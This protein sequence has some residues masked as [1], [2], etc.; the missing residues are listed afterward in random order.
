MDS[1]NNEFSNS[2]NNIASTS[3]NSREKETLDNSEL[4][5]KGLQ[6]LLE[7]INN[8]NHNNLEQITNAFI[9]TIEN[10]KIRSNNEDYNSINV[11]TKGDEGTN[12]V[13]F[14][15]KNF[16]LT[17]INFQQ[18]YK[19]LVH[20][21]ISTDLINF[22]EVQ[23]ETK[24][25][26]QLEIKKDN[27]TQS[28]IEYSLDEEGNDVLKGCKTAFEMMSRLKERYYQT[29]QSYID[30]I[31][32]QIKGLKIKDNDFLSYIHKMDELYNLR[33]TECDKLNKESLDDI[34]KITHIFKELINTRIHPLF[35]YLVDCNSY[36]EFKEKMYKLNSLMVTIKNLTDNN[37]FD[38]YNNNINRVQK[39]KLPYNFNF[40]KNTNQREKVHI[41][42][43]YC[44]ICEKYGHITKNCYKIKTNQSNSSNNKINKG[45]KRK[46]KLKTKKYNKI[47][48]SCNVENKIKKHT[49]QHSDSDSDVIKSLNFNS[50]YVSCSLAKNDFIKG[51]NKKRKFE[52]IDTSKNPNISSTSWIIDSGTAINLI[53]D[54]NKLTNVKE[55]EERTITYANG[56]TEIIKYVGMYKGEYKNKIFSIPNVYFASN[57]KNN[58]IS[59]NHILNMGFEL[60]IRKI[61]NKKVLTITKNNKYI[62][63]LNSNNEGLFVMKS[64]DLQTNNDVNY[65]EGIDC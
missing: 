14:H 44:Y 47:L 54:C 52:D 18:W 24:S 5:N 23:K 29:G 1:K 25:M 27:K 33:K 15:I 10:M 30:N 55:I 20:H 7:A 19:P 28:I 43:N 11:N 48:K 34:Y 4:V 16:H 13:P 60:N 39:G 51:H 46:L 65:V 26:N 8:N 12:N 50:N 49:N 35:V 32:K 61:R 58:L 45:R 56:T 9:K 64:K 6:K 59:T 21:L 57:I 22:I 37:N 41:E 36:D 38:K 42:D 31:D 53:K 62:I 3:S 17:S 2:S 63:N 40:D